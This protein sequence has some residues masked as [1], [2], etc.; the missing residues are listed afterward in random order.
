MIIARSR[1]EQLNASQLNEGEGDN[2]DTFS[3]LV[4]TDNHLGYLEKDP[5]RG[6]DSFEAFE[7][8]L[9]IAAKSEASLVVHP[10]KLEVQRNVIAASEYH[11]HALL[12][13]S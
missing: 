4:A 6:D 7:E 11:A 1:Q 5:V 9:E 2:E 10:A 8:I 3:I 13:R 12:V